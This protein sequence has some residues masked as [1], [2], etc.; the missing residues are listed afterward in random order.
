ML[1]G[2][3]MVLG[4]VGEAEKDDIGLL[5]KLVDLLQKRQETILM[6]LEKLTDSG[7]ALNPPLLN[8]KLLEDTIFIWVPLVQ[9]RVGHNL[10]IRYDR[11][12][13]YL[14]VGLFYSPLA[15]P[16]SA[17]FVMSCMYTMCIFVK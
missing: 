8:C 5:T 3:S 14:C 9:Q 12:F 16:F 17:K 7:S 10:G 6:E 15:M 4:Q 2:F 13:L 1:K 11:V